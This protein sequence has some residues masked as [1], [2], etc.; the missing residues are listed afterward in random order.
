VTLA[1]ALA[2]IAPS[3]VAAQL[4][5][6]PA[7]GI[8][9]PVGALIEDDVSNGGE[10]RRQLGAPLIAFRLTAWPRAR[11]R[12]E[13]SAAFSPSQVAVSRAGSTADFAS[14]VM[15]AS[16]RAVVAIGSR[17]ATWA[18]HAGAGLGVVSRGGSVWADT[19][20]TTAPVAVLA[21]G[22]RTGVRQTSLAIRLELEDY[23]ASAQ[24]DRG[25]PTET[26]ARIHHDLLWS[27][28]ISVPVF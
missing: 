10:V 24:L 19:R 16:A 4:E 8:Y 18:F 6:S 7:L 21:A 1:V 27:L 14:G 9:M 26:R 15:L 12:L 20:G 5:I 17:T 22:A 11:L 2:S 25:L 23:V 28:G 13:G 3:R